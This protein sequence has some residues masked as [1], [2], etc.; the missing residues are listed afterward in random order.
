MTLEEF[1]TAIREICNDYQA[2]RLTE[3]QFIEAVFNLRNRL[4]ISRA[5]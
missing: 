2:S 1:E 3:R 4:D 5:A